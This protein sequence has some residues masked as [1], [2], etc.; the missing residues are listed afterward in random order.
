MT[1]E[2]DDECKKY[3][4]QNRVEVIVQDPILN[5]KFGVGG[6]IHGII[7]AY[8]TSDTFNTIS[9][10]Q[11]Q[12]ERDNIPVEGAMFV[13]QPPP[14]TITKFSGLVIADTIAE[15]KNKYDLI[16]DLIRNPMFESRHF[17]VQPFTLLEF[18]YPY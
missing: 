16:C 7:S 3:G 5:G 6:Y 12:P 13:Y 4:I 1:D 9:L 10:T 14:P 8:Y 2:K 15:A 17:G 11:L 18:K